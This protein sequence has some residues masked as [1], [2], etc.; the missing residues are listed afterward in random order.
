MI[1]TDKEQQLMKSIIE[2][3]D[4]PGCGWLHE[5]NPFMNDRVCAG[6]LSALIQKGLVRSDLYQD[7]DCDDCYWIEL[8]I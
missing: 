5:L 3:M 8:V 4:E 1:L 6:V 2:G 7:R